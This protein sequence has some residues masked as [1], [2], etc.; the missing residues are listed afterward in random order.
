MSAGAARPRVEAP[1][2]L[3]PQTVKPDQILHELSKLWNNMT[4]P[5]PGEA[6]EEYTLREPARLRHDLDRLRQ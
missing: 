5:Q 1:V 6:P 2:T 3:A 4:K